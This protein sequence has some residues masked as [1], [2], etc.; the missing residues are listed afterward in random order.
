MLCR[1]ACPGLAALLSLITVLA[2]PDAAATVKFFYDPETGNVS[3]DTTQTRSNEL[4]SIS[5]YLPA[6][7]VPSIVEHVPDEIM[8]LRF[9]NENFVRLSNSPYFF[10]KPAMV[11]DQM[12]GQPAR[13]LHTLGDIL[14]VGLT[15]YTWERLFARYGL[16]GD[17][18]DPALRDEYY[19]QHGYT[20]AIGQGN[21]PPAE[22]I[23]G[24]PGRPFD[25][26]WDLVDPDTLQWAEQATLIYHPWS[27]ELVLDTTGPNSGHIASLW[28]KSS[29]PRLRVEHAS[30]VSG[31]TRF[32]SVNDDLVYWGDA[33]EP[34]VYSLGNIL[35]TAISIDE[36]ETMFEERQ[37][38]GREGFGQASL[39]FATHGVSI[40]LVYLPEPVTA[41]TLL[42]TAGLFRRRL[43]D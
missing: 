2:A 14:P 23:Y 15:A 20:D 32:P 35:A 29:D 37:F 30:E 7:L 9:R 42:L 18:H 24:H 25:N 19:G 33:L 13:G 16:T 21:P 43:L 11:T 5:L 31:M 36:L 22:F 38:I 28:L 6:G 34:G 3:F 17:T 39:D 12:I 41:S 26:R 10:N 8:A 27:G 4:L 1:F 40:N